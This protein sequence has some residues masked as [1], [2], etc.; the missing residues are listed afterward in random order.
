MKIQHDKLAYEDELF[1]FLLKC[2]KLLVLRE[3]GRKVH[4]QATAANIK[5]HDPPLLS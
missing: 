5:S 2:G 4:R 1:V 3:I